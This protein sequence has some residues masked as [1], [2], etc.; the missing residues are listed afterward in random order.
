M[1]ANTTNPKSCSGN[2]ITI[3]IINKHCKYSERTK[4]YVF[5]VDITDCLEN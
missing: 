2:S 4:L 1:P 5:A 3:R